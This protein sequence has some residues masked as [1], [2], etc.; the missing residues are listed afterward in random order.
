MIEAKSITLKEGS[1]P[2]RNKASGRQV[3]GIQSLLKISSVLGSV[4]FIL[5]F[6][7]KSGI[8]SLFSAELYI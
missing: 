1:F 3:G 2:M 6:L 8:Y 5:S 7:L 4:A